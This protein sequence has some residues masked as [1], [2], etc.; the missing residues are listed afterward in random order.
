M[1]TRTADLPIGFRRLK[2]NWNADLSPLLA[3]AKSA[4]FEA[5]DLNEAT[6][7]DVAA[8][9][10][11]GLRLG[12]VDLLSMGR[13][14][15]KDPGER[16]DVIGRNVAYVRE[17]ATAGVTTFFTVLIPDDPTHKRPDNYRLAVETFAPLAQ[18][19]AAAGARIAIEGWPGPAPHFPALC[20]TPESCR[21]FLRDTDPRGVAINYDP[22]HLVRLGVDP[23]RF[24]EEFIA[25][26]PHVHA[27]DTELFPDAAYE[28]G[29]YQDSIRPD[30]PPHRYGAHAWR[31]T[32]PGHGATPWP[33]IL[34][35]LR[36]HNYPGA[37]SVELED[38]NFNGAEATERAGLLHSLNFLRGL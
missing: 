5:F 3:W 11:A 35:V 16:R 15:A 36:N 38:E 22:S 28:L 29:V 20:C 4:G 8:V 25:A 31:Y 33:A 9:R 23:V 34:R 2:S 10:A 27:K 21:A 37:I 19:A 18:A 30:R 24:L 32:I 6:P 17:L 1:P 7:A 14:L 12:T 26:V 13:L